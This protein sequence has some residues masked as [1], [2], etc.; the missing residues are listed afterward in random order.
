M[1][2]LMIEIVSSDDLTTSLLDEIREWL[3]SVFIEVGDQTEWSSADWHV[4]GWIDGE[5]ISHADVVRRD[6]L[7]GGSK[8]SVGG[9]G[10]VVTK[11][12]WRGK[13]FGS[14]LMREAHRFMLDEIEVDF[15]LLMCDE[16]L[17]PFYERLGWQIA[18]NP[19]VYDQPSGKV[20]FDDAVMVLP[21]KQ[22]GFPDGEIDIHGYPW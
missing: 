7:V 1:G 10:G 11:A 9:V 6:V 13:G 5:L 12:R 8:V 21:V 2:Q 4:L 18:R 20:L 3:V 16:A 19:L 14:R 17:V 15:G 22:D